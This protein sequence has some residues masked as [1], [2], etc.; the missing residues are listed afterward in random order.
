MLPRPLQ[1]AKECVKEIPV[2]NLTDFVD[3]ALNHVLERNT[4]ARQQTGT[5][6]HDLV[7]NTVL[8]TEQYLDGSVLCHLSFHVFTAHKLEMYVY[9]VPAQ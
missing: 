9:V 2:K 3:I 4:K 6:L 7:I 5:L 1:E 8:T